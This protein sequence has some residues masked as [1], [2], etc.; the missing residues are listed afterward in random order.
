MVLVKCW[1]RKGS[2]FPHVRLRS[3]TLVL[4]PKPYMRILTRLGAGSDENLLVP[5]WLVCIREREGSKR[6]VFWKG[7]ILPQ[8]GPFPEAGAGRTRDQRPFQSYISLHL[9]AGLP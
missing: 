1:L 4:L 8:F 7:E 3:A 6:R 5:G 2:R 9:H